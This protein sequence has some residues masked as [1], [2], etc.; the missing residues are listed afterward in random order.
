MCCYSDGSGIVNQVRKVWMT[1]P[2]V[3]TG[4]QCLSV[5][6]EQITKQKEANKK[7]LE[8]VAESPQIPARFQPLWLSQIVNQGNHLNI[9]TWWI[10][11]DMTYAMSGDHGSVQSRIVLPL[12]KT[13]SASMYNRAY[14]HTHSS[15][16]QATSARVVV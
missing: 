1:G 12:P 14:L 2:Q 7:W 5:Y 4:S 6:A 16:P 10:R 3:N 15:G 9:F 8:F 13:K 11:S